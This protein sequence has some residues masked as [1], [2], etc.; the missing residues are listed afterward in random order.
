MKST[1]TREGVIADFREKIA[2]KEPIIISSPGIGLISKMCAI[3]GVD[4]QIIC[5]AAKFNLDA[6]PSILANMAYGDS[7]TI[8]LDL[9]KRCIEI[10][11]STPFVAGVAA[12]D[13]YRARQDLFEELEKA[14]FIG[15]VNAPSACID[16]DFFTGPG[17]HDVHE[18]KKMLGVYKDIELIKDAHDYGFFTIA[19]VVDEEETKLMIEAGADAIIPHMGFTTGGINGVPEELAPTLDEACE[20]TQALCAYAKSL[21]PDVFVFAHGGPFNAP[22]PVGECFKRTDVDGFWGNS[23]IGRIPTENAMIRV[24]SEYVDLERPPKKGGAKA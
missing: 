16:V 10:G 23:A 7:N 11:K 20:K 2:R 14:G 19:I 22:E 12:L 6:H 9:A 21:K 1:F 24:I 18:A 4:M 3:A 17:G 8:M 5:S 13:P 15:V